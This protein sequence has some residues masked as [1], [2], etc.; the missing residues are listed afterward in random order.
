M[1]VE[2]EEGEAEEGGKNREVEEGDEPRA[3]GKGEV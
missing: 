1:L 2:E 3:K